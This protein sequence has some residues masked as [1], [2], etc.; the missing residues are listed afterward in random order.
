[1]LARY[2]MKTCKIEGDPPSAILSRKGV[3]QYVDPE[4]LQ[5]GFAVNFS[6]WS[7]EF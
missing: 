6:I 7:G 5:S 3:A 4:V 1:M 2:Y